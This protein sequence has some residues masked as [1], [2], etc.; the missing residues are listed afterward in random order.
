MAKNK[1]KVF[2]DAFKASLPGHCLLI[3][4]PD[5]PH[6]WDREGSSTRFAPKNPCDFVMFDSNARIQYCL[7]LKSTKAKSM[8]FDD[9]SLNYSE[10]K[11]VKQHQIKALTGFA[12]FPY[13]RAGFLFNFRDEA[14]NEERTYYQD[15]VSF[16]NMVSKIGKKSFNEKDLGLH[17]AIV[18]DGKIKRVKYTWDIEGLLGK[19][20]DVYEKCLN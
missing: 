20:D 13:V 16:N 7:E 14:N 11:M 19:L 18:V 12:K 15:I 17:N 5:P 9:V 3:R 6:S 10:G 2:E 4:I 8:S 1:G